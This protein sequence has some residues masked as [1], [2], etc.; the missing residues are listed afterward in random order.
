[1]CVQLTET[2][3]LVVRYQCF[4]WLPVT[5][6][7]RCGGA[8]EGEGVTVRNQFSYALKMVGVACFDDGVGDCRLQQ[9][10]KNQQ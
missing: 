7:V 5:G 6:G 8:G 2:S 3:S 10:I 4:T 1:M 9:L